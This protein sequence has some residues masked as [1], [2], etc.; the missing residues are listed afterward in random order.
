[1]IREPVSLLSVAP[2]ILDLVGAPPEPRHEGRSLVPLMRGGAVPSAAV[3]SELEPLGDGPDIRVHTAAVFD[4]DRAALLGTN[5]GVEV[6]DI[7]ADPREQ[8]PLPPLLAAESLPLVAALEQAQ[9]RPTDAS[10]NL[11]ARPVDD[12]T[13]EKLRALGYQF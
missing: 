6:Y 4:N 8:H 5:G 9:A 13:K 2:T 7:G 3:V 10:A 11:I 12:A 1:V